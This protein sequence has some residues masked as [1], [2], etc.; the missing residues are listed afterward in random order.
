MNSVKR[1]QRL[2]KSFKKSKMNYKL[3][4]LPKITEKLAS[5]FLKI[6]AQ[7]YAISKILIFNEMISNSAYFDNNSQFSAKEKN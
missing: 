2:P 6:S 3:T 1:F 5:I 4:V 7:K